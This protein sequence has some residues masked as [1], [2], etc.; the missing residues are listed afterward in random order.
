MRR[1]RKAAS[2]ELDAIAERSDGAMSAAEDSA[3]VPPI[4]TRAGS[5]AA[6]LRLQA[7]KKTLLDDAACAAHV[8][9]IRSGLVR[10]GDWECEA[11]ES[12]KKEVLRNQQIQQKAEAAAAKTKE[13]REEEEETEKAD[14]NAEKSCCSLLS[15]V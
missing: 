4:W 7:A 10:R 15:R 14:R 3:A 2:C 11:R 8:D 9:E 13:E 6:F 12:L 5:E 1:S